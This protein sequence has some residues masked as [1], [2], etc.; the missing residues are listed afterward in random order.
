MPSTAGVKFTDV[1]RRMLN[2]LKKAGG[3]GTR[4]GSKPSGKSGR[5]G[6]RNGGS[7]RLG[8][9]SIRPMML[10]SVRFSKGGR[11]GGR[12]RF[13]K[14]ANVDFTRRTVSIAANLNGSVLTVYRAPISQT[15]KN[16]TLG[17]N[18]STLIRTIGPTVPLGPNGSIGTFQGQTITNSEKQVNFILAMILVK[19]GEDIDAVAAKV[20][21][22]LPFPQLGAGTPGVSPGQAAALQAA[23]EPSVTIQVVG[24]NNEII[25]EGGQLPVVQRVALANGEP[26]T[27]NTVVE[28]YEPEQDIIG[29]RIGTTYFNQTGLQNAIIR[30]RTKKRW[31][32]QRGDSIVVVLKPDQ[33]TIAPQAI[34]ASLDFSCIS[35]Q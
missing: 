34:G 8:R 32:L 14:K 6:N 12:R 26:D 16:L 27:V 7:R 1:K 2:R 29:Y 22:P 13:G 19:S 9:G 30:I 3:S 17:G 10:R 33:D 4:G 15:V 35:L 23:E 18:V 21:P 11:S 28:A 25:R 31:E 5:K 24:P 20:N